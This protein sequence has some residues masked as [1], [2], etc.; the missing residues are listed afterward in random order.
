MK[1]GTCVVGWYPDPKSKGD[2]NLKPVKCEAVMQTLSV[3]VARQALGKSLNKGE[4]K[5]VKHLVKN[6]KAGV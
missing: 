2:T 5:I 1:K 6:Y 3:I 4:R